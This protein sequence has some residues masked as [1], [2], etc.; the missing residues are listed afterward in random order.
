MRK[1]EYKYKMIAPIIITV[2]IVLYYLFY[3]TVLTHLLG[4]V[5]GCLLGI[6]PI[7]FA[8]TMIYVCV[9]R[10]QEIRSGEEDDLS[11]Y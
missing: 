10:I 2:V 9:Q 6:F 8:A 11:K 1:P 3:F 5:L 4:G 7:L